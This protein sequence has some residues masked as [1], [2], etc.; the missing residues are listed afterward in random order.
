MKTVLGFGYAGKKLSALVRN[1]TDL[2]AVVV[3]VR[4]KPWAKDPDFQKTTL[5]RVLGER[6]VTGG[7]FLGNRNYKEGPIEIVD[8]RA[9][10]QLLESIPNEHV[11]LLCFCWDFNTCHRKVIANH[12]QTLGYA[13]Y[14]LTQ[15][16]SPVEKR[17]VPDS[18]QLSF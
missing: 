7:H 18:E 12:L 1:V 4:F 13:Y 17:V 9:G 14:E 16:L 8:L 11:V 6:Y 3:D 5:S 2:D 10:V 15:Y